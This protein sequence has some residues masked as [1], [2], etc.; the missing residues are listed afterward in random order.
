M[1]PLLALPEVYIIYTMNSR[2]YP[3]TG[4]TS[5]NISCLAGSK[6]GTVILS[7]RAKRLI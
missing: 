1:S 6:S 7:V 5:S 3:L 4:V 2:T